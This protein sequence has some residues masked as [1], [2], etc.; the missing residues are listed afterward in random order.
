MNTSVFLSLS[1]DYGQP[2]RNQFS[3]TRTYLYNN[4]YSFR[5]TFKSRQIL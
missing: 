1:G 3:I 5:L 2:N 4:F